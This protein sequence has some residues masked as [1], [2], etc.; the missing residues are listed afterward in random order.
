MNT[1]PKIP[2]GTQPRPGILRRLLKWTLRITGGI[3]TLLI[4]LVFLAQFLAPDWTKRRNPAGFSVNTLHYLT[5]NE[6]SEVFI[7]VWLPPNLNPGEKIPTLIHTTRYSHQDEPGWLHNVFQAY[8]GQLDMNYAG[9]K[10]RMDAGF[11]FVLVQSPGSCQSS[12]PRP[13]DYPPSEIDAIGIAIDWIARQPWSNQKVGAFGTSYSAT[14]ADMSCASLRPQLKAVY[15]RAPDFDPFT[16]VIKPGGVGSSEFLACW[17]GYVKGMDADDYVGAV[18][19][20]MGQKLSFV[21]RVLYRSMVKGLK[22]PRG[23]DLAI[24]QQALKDHLSNP[25]VGKLYNSLEYRDTPFSA[26]D[27]MSLENVALY[28]YKDRMEKAQVNTYT[29]AGWMDA[30]VAEGSLQKFLTIRSP[31]K[32]VLLPTGHNQGEFVNPY[33]PNTKDVPLEPG[34]SKQDMLDYFSKHLK[35]GPET[36]EKRTILYYTYGSGSWRETDIW[37]PRGIQDET[38]YFGENNSLSPNKPT[39]EEGADTYTVDFTTSAGESNRWLAQL[40]GSVNYGD[41]RKEDEK[42]LC[43]TS[44][45]LQSDVE[46]TGSPTV[47]LH[48]A[49]THSDGAFHVYFEEV[50]PEGRVSYLSEGIL[51]AVHRKTRDSR[52]APYVPLGVYRT[53]WETDARPL[54]P[55]EV[56][57]IPITLQPISVVIPK[58]HRIR[59]AIAGHD[60][61]LKS[62]FPTSGTPQLSFRRN[63]VHPAG[64]RLPV[65]GAR[66]Y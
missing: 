33:G 1:G 21:D 49:S 63:A 42:L 5:L 10:N 27:S 12:G 55:G 25:D 20:A 37:P 24:F 36:R 41:R 17:G 15:A 60:A 19:A 62:R 34:S 64:L 13:Y 52:T 51:R 18:D 22:R 66:D 16:G 45:P 43:Y 2:K 54:V 14:T 30:G 29:R 28:N 11:A 50:A 35:D 53:Y 7:S 56:A 23:K 6:Q 3:V 9:A 8:F 44:A 4:A 40:K 26:A 58:G 46:V 47:T 32:L 61:A 57:E 38:W 31:Q 39:L 48:V 59:V 65:M